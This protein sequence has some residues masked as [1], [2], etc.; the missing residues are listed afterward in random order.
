MPPS[1][2]TFA[3]A[4]VD[5]A[6]ER[7]VDKAWQRRVLTEPGTVFVPV[8]QGR[9]P[10]DEAQAR[11]V[12]LRHDE[13]GAPPALEDLVFLG[14]FR[15]KPAFALEVA[16]PV[17]PPGSEAAY[18]D[19]RILGGLLPPDEASLMA[20]ARAMIL[21]HEAQRHCGHCGAPTVMDTGGYARICT[22]PGCARRIFP[23]VDPA[24]IVLVVSG[25]DCLLGRQSSWPTG[26]Y[27]TIAGFVEP[28]ESLEEAVRREVFE[29]TNV[30]L[31]AVHY[32]SSQPWPFPSALMLGFRATAESRE[33]VLND[34]ELEDARWFRRQEILDGQ[35]RLPPPLSIA[36]R[37]VDDWLREAG[38][39]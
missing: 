6:G 37:L 15:D 19:L 29:E 9:C 33:I 21:W 24:I 1:H 22:D 2:N 26:R 30:R 16:E 13:L 39:D 25:D 5:R 23:R 7:R 27:S 3:G 38:G 11:A 36:R 31:A 20:H 4:Y 35:P 34:G 12:L 28:G 8:W 32:Q 10:A 14:L 18:R 17:L